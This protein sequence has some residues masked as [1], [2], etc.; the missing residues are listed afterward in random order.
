MHLEYN[1]NK[2]NQ[3]KSSMPAGT[4]VYE[5]YY[6]HASFLGWQEETKPVNFSD[7]IHGD[8]YKEN[9]VLCVVSEK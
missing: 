3:I 1:E 9:G 4:T 6:K 8:E 2:W 5:H 7:C